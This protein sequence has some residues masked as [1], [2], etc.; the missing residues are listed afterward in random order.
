VSAR[1]I[2]PDVAVSAGDAR[3]FTLVELLVATVIAGVVLGGAYGWAW[4]VGALAQVQDDR[5]QAGTV[6]AA[7]ARTITADVRASIAAVAPEAGRDP[8]RSLT[9]IHDRVGVAP[10]SVVI[11]WDPARRVVWRNASGTYVADHVTSFHVEYAFHDGRRVGGDA[12]AAADWRSVAAVRV[13][14]TAQVGSASARRGVWVSLGN[15]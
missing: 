8:S 6:A 3:G 14:L 5:A 9:L 4:N 13:V 15:G 10:A 1:S 12:M 2:C 11:V 7:V